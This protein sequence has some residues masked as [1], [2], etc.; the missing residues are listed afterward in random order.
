MKPVAGSM[1]MVMIFSGVSMR[2]VLDVHAA[3]GRGDHRDAALV[4]VD[5]QREVEF[6]GDVG[7][8]G[9]VE[10]VDLLAAGP[11]WIVTSVLPSMSVALAFTS[12]IGLGQAHTAL[13]VGA[14]FLELAL[15]A[16]AGVDLR[17]HDIERPG[18]LA[19]RRRRLRPRSGGGMAPN[20]ASRAYS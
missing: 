2:D 6:L 12:S 19:S 8:V 13:G 20:F 5:Q 1:V 3:F 11:V 14:E 16:S 18:Q 9:D 7:A 17:L 10:A 15:A 4:R